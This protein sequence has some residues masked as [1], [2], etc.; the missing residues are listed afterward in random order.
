MGVF[1][2]K[3][4]T[5]QTPQK[6]TPVTAAEVK[7]T[8]TP[9]VPVK[10]STPAAGKPSAQ[11]SQ[12]TEAGPGSSVINS[13]LWFDGTLKFEGSLTLDCEIRGTITTPDTLIVGPSARVQAEISAGS[14]EI[15]GKVNGNIRAKK[16]VKIF[17][18]GEVYGN[19][20]T[21][22]VSMEEGV[23][24][25]GNCT[26]PRSQQPQAKGPSGQPVASIP[27]K[28]AVPAQKPNVQSP[29]TGPQNPTAGSSE[30]KSTASKPVE[31]KA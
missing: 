22:N 24:F 26:R 19:I 17:A 2:R 29:V 23:V 15:S 8:P 12:R 27:P 6:A 30:S 10:A 16:N 7:A 5:E 4:A 31:V 1:S 9:A 21:P 14:V 3:K 28:G 20:E 13:H 18:G 25:E 11:L